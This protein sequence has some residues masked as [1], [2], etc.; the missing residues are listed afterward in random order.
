[1]KVIIEP[2]KVPE[3]YDDDGQRIDGIVS[4]NYGYVTRDS[5]DIGKNEMN[6]NYY[7]LQRNVVMHKGWKLY[8]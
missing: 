2:G 8:E 1:M 4:F 3:I 5:K 7:S 6:V